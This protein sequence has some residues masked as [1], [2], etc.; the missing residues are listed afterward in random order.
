MSAGARGPPRHRLLVALLAVTTVALALRLVD[1]GGRVAHWDEARVAYWTLRYLDLGVWEYHPV[2]HGPFQFHVNATVFGLIG[3]DDVSMRLVVALIAGGSPLAA[4]LYRS[5]L[6][7]A[8]VL[9][10]GGLLAANPVLLYY[11]RFARNDAMLAVAMLV[12]F[13]LLL[14]AHDTGRSAYLYP[15]ALAIALGFT[16]KENALLYLMCWGGAAIAVVGHRL[17][18]ERVAPRLGR[19]P[20]PLALRSTWREHLPDDPRRWARDGGLSVGVGLAVLV[21]FYA[22]RG[23]DDPGLGELVTAPWRLPWVVEASVVEGAR[24]L[25]AHWIVGGR[26]PPY[27]DALGFYLHVLAAGA[28]VV[29]AFAV[30]GLAV[31][32]VRPGPPRWLVVFAL[33]WGLLSVGGYPYA[34]TINAPWLATHMVAPLAIPAAVGLAEVYELARAGAV[35]GDALQAVAAGLILL[36]AVGLVLVPMYGLVY[37]DPTGTDNELVQFAQPGGD[38][39]DTIELMQALAAANEG[40][41]VLYVGTDFATDDRDGEA[42]KQAGPGW[43]DR[44]PLPWYTE[45]VGAETVS[46]TGQADALERIEAESPPVVIARPGQD[47]LVS[48]GL[49]GYELRAHA[50]RQSITDIHIYLDLDRLDDAA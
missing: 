2:V 21:V 39:G 8:E 30:V 35:D 22:P 29:V 40:P 25:I 1:L 49:D 42:Y 45:Q 5:H 43:Y 47:G 18:Y 28:I 3:A 31:E 33:V 34:G 48:G 7:H 16:M 41:D 17:A 50:M 10:M 4:W 12:A 11:G 32:H 24:R 9:V 13:G 46:E 26:G 44:L 19:A 23:T 20:A 37:D 27:L 36:A 6:S 14:R 15:A 38:W